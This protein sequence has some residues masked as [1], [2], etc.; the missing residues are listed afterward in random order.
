VIE[1]VGTENLQPRSREAVLAFLE[2]ALSD[3]GMLT[4]QV[5]GTAARSNAPAGQFA[6][7]QAG[8]YISLM[9]Q[10]FRG[11]IQV[12]GG[13]T[14]QTIGSAV[15]LGAEFIVCGSEIFRNQEGRS[16]ETVIDELLLRAAAALGV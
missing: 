11:T 16:M 4:F 5:A 1:T 14:A 8:S 9:R 15:E 2:P 13:M 10:A 6:H 3:V 12:Q 7:Q